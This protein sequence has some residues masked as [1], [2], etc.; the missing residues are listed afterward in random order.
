MQSFAS[1]QHCLLSAAFQSTHQILLSHFQILLSLQARLLPSLVSTIF[2][3]LSLFRSWY[4]SSFSVSFSPTLTSAGTAI[5]MIIPFPYFLSIKIMSGLVSSITLSYWTLISHNTLTSSFSTA[6][7]E[8]CSY[9]FSVCYNPCFWQWSQWIF[10]ATLSCLILY[11][12]WGNIS[13]LSVAH[14]HFSF[15]IIWTGAFHRS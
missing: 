13:H 12:F 15:Y 2:H 10:F 5:S 14:F 6:P 8:M 11:S 3:S 4:F 1:L 9:H 7:S